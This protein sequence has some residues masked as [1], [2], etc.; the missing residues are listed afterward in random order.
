MLSVGDQVCGRDGK[1]SRLGPALGSHCKGSCLGGG[2]VAWM[3]STVVPVGVAL[4]R[5]DPSGME[6]EAG[7][8]A[9]MPPLVLPWLGVLQS[10]LATGA[11]ERMGLLPQR[12]WPGQKNS[13]C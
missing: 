9:W 8:L 13:M 7:G 10:V 11:T 12:S 5:K 4:G 3:G 2:P 6:P 1:M